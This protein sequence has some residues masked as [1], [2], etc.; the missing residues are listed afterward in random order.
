[1]VLAMT[2]ELTL[3]ITYLLSCVRLV[4]ISRVFLFYFTLFY[5]T[6]DIHY[7]IVGKELARNAFHNS[8][9]RPIK[10]ETKI[11]TYYQQL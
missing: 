5:S 2:L 10:L 7:C 4:S 11:E 1:M 9:H 8:E 3:Y 6:T